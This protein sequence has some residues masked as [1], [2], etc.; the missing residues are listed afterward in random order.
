MTGY[1]RMFKSRRRRRRGGMA[2]KL[3]QP[4][5]MYL[6]VCRLL[7]DLCAECSA[8]STWNNVASDDEEIYQ[9]SELNKGKRGALG[10]EEIVKGS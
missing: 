4:H 9:F 10:E 8:S 6:A 3:V 1:V 7:I 5:L 2:S